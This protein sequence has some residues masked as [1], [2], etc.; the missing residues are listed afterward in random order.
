VDNLEEVLKGHTSSA[1]YPLPLRVLAS[2]LDSD[3]Q[4][5][6]DIDP[7]ITAEQKPDAKKASL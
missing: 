7:E 3:K 1:W 4:R 6:I 2:I 5:Q